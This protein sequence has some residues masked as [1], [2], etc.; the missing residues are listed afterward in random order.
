MKAVITEQHAW[1]HRLVGEWRV[2]MTSMNG[3]AQPPGTMPGSE[4]VRRLGD[5]W[6]ILDGRGVAPDN[7]PVQTQMTLGHDPMRGDYAGTWIGS[8]MNHLWVYRGALADDGR[9]LLLD[10]DG[11]AFDDPGRTERYRDIIEIVSNDERLLH[12]NLLRPDGQWL[13][14]MTARY[15]RVR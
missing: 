10:S 9:R 15:T 5:A 3:V 4:S 6:V 13:H 12:G 1:L 8:M 2:E 11:P 7:S 14:F